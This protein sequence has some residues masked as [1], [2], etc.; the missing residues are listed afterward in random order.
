MPARKISITG[1][2][3]GVFFRAHTE[4]KARELE[5]SGWVRNTEKNGVEIHAEGPENAL[6]K[7]EEWC[8]QGPPAAIVEG[9]HV[10]DAEEEGCQGFGIR[11]G[12]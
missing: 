1:H 10:E 12:L 8:Y 9:V 11:Y 4:E 3:Q 2:V 5:L 6:R 7:L